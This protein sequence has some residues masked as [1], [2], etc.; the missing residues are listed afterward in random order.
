VTVVMTTHLLV[1]II[2]MGV[3]EISLITVTLTVGILMDGFPTGLCLTG[4]C[5]MG[6][7]LRGAILRVDI[8]RADTPIEPYFSWQIYQSEGGDIS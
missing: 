3:E 5:L 4:I 2:R 1:A 7:Y 6:I 8:L